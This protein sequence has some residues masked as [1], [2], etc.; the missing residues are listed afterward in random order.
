MRNQ[1]RNILEYA[2]WILLLG[3]FLFTR[4]Y[5]ILELPW[6][7]HID[8]AGMAYD[9]WCLS[10]F[11]YDRH[12]LSWP[13]YLKNF[14]GGQSSLYAFL[15]AGFFKLFGYHL[16]WVRLPGII[17]S[18]LT[19]L[20]GAKI[21]RFIYPDKKWLFIVTAGL[22]TICPYFVLASRFG[23]DCN[24]FLGASTMFLYCFIRA[25]DSGK[26]K[27]YIWAGIAGGVTLYTYAISY[28]IV[29]AFLVLSFVYALVTKKFALKKW[30]VMAIPMGVLAAP[31][32]AIQIINMFDLPQKT[33]FGIFTL[34]KLEF[35]R[36]SEI[37]MPT[38]ANIKNLILSMFKDDPWPYNSVPGFFQLY[39]MSIPLFATGFITTFVRLFKALCKKTHKLEAYLSGWF[40]VCFLIG[41]VT[42]TNSNKINAIF[43]VTI[44]FV[45]EGIHTIITSLQNKKALVTYGV[46]GLIVIL[47]MGCFVNFS[48]YYYGGQYRED[49][50][51]MLY[52]FPIIT[53][54]VQYLEEHPEKKNAGTY[55]DEPGIVL[56]ISS[57]YPPEKLGNMED[58]DWSAT[59]CDGYYYCRDL[60]ARP[61]YNYIINHTNTSY[62]QDFRAM[63]YE[64]I[65][66]DGYS[67]FIYK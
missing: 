39:W 47:Y 40:L 61:N 8:E 34:T 16:F 55:M 58:A 41:M 3:L 20:F 1:R 13:L 23:L 64:E 56:A 50:D 15:T 27:F 57:L 11:G 22:L 65:A 52:F 51:P 26:Y 28:M 66:F 43:F 10:E 60:T 67:L 2:I 29:P 24:L 9:A 37:G 45:V 5:L 36:A 46:A 42:E 12:L 49:N 17:F 25:M 59:Y 19:V 33:L 32:M 48:H 54:A 6:G 38:F 53:E 44:Y 31:L 30:L 14:G 35:Y 4:F 63:G 18:A 7:I 62:L 21:V